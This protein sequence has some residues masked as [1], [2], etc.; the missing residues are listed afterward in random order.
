[1][2]TDPGHL[3]EFYEGFTGTCGECALE[4][5]L[6]EAAG[7]KASENDMVAIVHEMQQHGQLSAPNGASTMWD[8]AREAERRG[9]QVALEWDYEEPFNHDWVSVLRANYGKKPMV[10]QLAQAH[11]LRDVETGAAD[12]AGVHY[13]F[14]AIL[15]AK[16]DGY[17]AND[18]DNPQ[19]LSRYQVYNLGTLT[20]AVPCGL[21]VIEPKESPVATSGVPSGWADDGTT[22]TA[23]NGNKV[24]EGFRDTIL[25]WKG[26]WPA[27][28]WPSSE[29]DSENNSNM[30]LSVGLHWEPNQ[31]ITVRSGELPPAPAPVTTTVNVVP[32]EVKAMLAQALNQFAAPAQLYNEASDLIK[33]YGN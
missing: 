29:F 24:T 22:L 14:I 21:L 27:F 19:V 26:G 17:I 16:A 11:N 4:D 18:G 28:V 32:A 6:S 3:T 8:L 2:N 12:E 25:G 33:K 7:T 5:A 30:V 15:N 13:H 1:M 10:L 20:N 9:F 23:P 31:P